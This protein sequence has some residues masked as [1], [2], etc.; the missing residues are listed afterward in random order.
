MPFLKILNGSIFCYLLSSKKNSAAPI[1]VERNFLKL[2]AKGVKR[3]ARSAQKCIP[4]KT[5]IV[6]FPGKVFFPLLTDSQSSAPFLTT[7]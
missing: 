6:S 2:S 5:Q 7:A 3:S 4:R 1:R